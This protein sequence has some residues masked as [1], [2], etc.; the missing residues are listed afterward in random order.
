MPP[1]VTLGE[2]PPQEAGAV[3]FIPKDTWIGGA[4][5][6]AEPATFVFIF[7]QMGIEDVFRRYSPKVGEPTPTPEERATILRDHAHN[8]VFNHR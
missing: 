8:M 3:V 4:N 1:T 5:R 2:D 7:P 6:G